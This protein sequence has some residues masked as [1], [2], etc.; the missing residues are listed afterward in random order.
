MLSRE[1][2]SKL[3][4]PAPEVVIAP[5]CYGQAQL[6]SSDELISNIQFFVLDLAGIVNRMRA[7]GKNRHELSW[8]STTPMTTGSRRLHAL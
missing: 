7:T 3:S 4:D 1:G 5:Y 6:A 2:F 8:G